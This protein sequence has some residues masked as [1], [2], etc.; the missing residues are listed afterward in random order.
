MYVSSLPSGRTLDCIIF[1]SLTFFFAL[2][3]EYTLDPKHCHELSKTD[4][5]N[6]YGRTDKIPLKIRDRN[7]AKKLRASLIVPSVNVAY[8]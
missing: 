3:G 2:R 8:S 1:C 5:I 7:Y 6:L 4:I